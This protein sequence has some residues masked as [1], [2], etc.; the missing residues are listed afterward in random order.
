MEMSFF[1]FGQPT[2]DLTKIWDQC[3]AHLRPLSDHLQLQEAEFETC[4]LCNDRKSIRIL[5]HLRF[6]PD[7]WLN[8]SEVL[9]CY[10]CD[11]YTLPS[12]QTE[13][14]QDQIIQWTKDKGLSTQ[15]YNQITAVDA[16][17]WTLSPT[18]LN[19]EPTT[20]CNFNCW[21]CIGRTMKQEDLSF[22]N[23]VSILD[24]SPT[25]KVIA[26]VGEGEPLLNKR[27]FDMVKL[28]K[29]R[30]IRAVS[31]SNGSALTQSVVKKICE[32]GLDYLSVSIDSIDPETFAQ[33]RIGGDLNRVWAGIERLVN[34]RDRHGFKYPVIGLKGSLFTYTKN[35]LPQIIKEAKKR[36]IDYLEGFQ[37]LNP[38]QSYVDIY[39]EEKRALLDDVKD[40]G[41]IIAR[42]ASDSKLPGSSEFFNRENINF[43]FFGKR[44]RLRPNCDE[45]WVYSLLSGDITPCCQIKYPFDDKWN[46]IRNPLESILANHHYE[47]MRFNLWNG[48]FLPDCD[49]CH[50]TLSEAEA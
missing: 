13:N 12:N 23:Y 31:L 9:Y 40:V 5:A 26:I 45:E 32:S 14:Y 36:G 29:E 47:N 43:S 35:E 4:P 19:L 2:T 16:R 42:D 7:C 1:N 34:Y 38:K 39:P 33:S 30:N 17:L 49:G 37:P 28:A 3:H 18:V 25:I 8:N 46:I 24:H 27:F 6:G 50:K 48:I 20:R 22:E 10:N 44:N 15:K 11:H 41:Q 21:Y